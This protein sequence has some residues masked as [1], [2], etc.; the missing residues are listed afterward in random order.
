MQVKFW[1]K[2]TVKTNGL[3]M[4]LRVL[5]TRPAAQAS[6]TVQAI[7]DAGHEVMALPCLVIAPIAADSSQGQLNKHLA[8]D[9]DAFAHI[10]VVSTNAAKHFLPLVEDYWPQWPAAQTWWGMGKTTKQALLEADIPNVRQPQG[11]ET[12]EHLLTELMDLVE[13]HEKILIVRGVGGRETLADSLRAH[14][15]TVAYVQCYE[16]LAPT[17]NTQEI[18]QL[19]DFA[20]QVV[21]LQSGETLQHYHDQ[22]SRHLA[23]QNKPVRLLLPSPRVA[24]LAISLGYEDCLQSNGASD[25]AICHTLAECG[26]SQTTG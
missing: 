5:V 17:F 14:G 26:L 8:M 3:A 6:S 9:L 21:V 2:Y 13:P 7:T 10:I 4:S 16:R 1:R 25:Q 18:N 19:V 20:P 15:C 24:E 22:L 11:G 23:K 12:S